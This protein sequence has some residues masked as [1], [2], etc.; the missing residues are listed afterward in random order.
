MARLGALL[1][2]LFARGGGPY[3]IEYRVTAKDGS[4]RHVGE[5]GTAFVDEAGVP[6]YAIG[7]VRD[8]TAAKRQEEEQ[9]KLEA[10]LQHAQ[11]I[12]SLG[13]LT[14][15]IAHDFNNLLAGILGY[16]ELL[17][18]RPDDAATRTKAVGV[19]REAGLRARDLVRQILTFSRQQPPQRVLV[20]ASTVLDEALHLLR[21]SLPAEVDIECSG[22][23]LELRVHGDPTQLHQLLM[24]LALNGAQAMPDGGRLG[25]G[26][27][28]CEV[29][30]PAAVQVRV[31]TLLAGP[32]V[33][34][35]VEDS[36]CGMPENVMGRMFE[37][38]FTTKEASQ[39]TG[40]GL[41]VVHGIVLGHK[42]ALAV[43]SAPGQGT[44]FEVYLPA[45]P[46]SA[47]PDTAGRAA[48]VQPHGERVLVVDDE[49]YLVNLA[50][51]FLKTL[52]YEVVGVESPAD[53]LARLWAE[54]HAF[55]A[56]IT[57]L[58]MPVMSGVVLARYVH[59]MAPHLPVVLVTGYLD[60][61]TPEALADS[62]VA[63]VVSKP[64]A[65]ADLAAALDKLRAG[66]TG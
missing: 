11:R 50:G 32:Y 44:R 25:L 54:P 56:V 66:R 45:W 4:V 55:W 42:G 64:Y 16:A 1:G 43:H 37:P 24:N 51:E 29:R 3:S 19:I 31:G 36:G 52:G 12:E 59:E 6:L 28:A 34:F 15:G 10:N 23:A 57:D 47:V 58:D 61:V 18:L 26:V 48:G 33:R 22:Q 46:D 27:S 65:I 14:G 41:S 13:K 20:R 40:L 60:E 35:V 38:F 62:G 9:H 21:R 8:V 39:G 30:D 53:V 2:E 17:Q 5:T 49:P 63:A 7:A